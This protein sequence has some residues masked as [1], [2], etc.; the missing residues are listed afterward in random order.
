MS[1]ARII[2]PDFFQSRSLARVSRDARLTFIGLWTEADAEGRGIAHPAILRG[3]IWP[4]DVDITDAVVVSH[5]YELASTG[6]ITVYESDGDA[7]FAVVSWHKH[8]SAAYRTGESKLPAP[9]SCRNSPETLYRLR[10]SNGELLYVGITR[11]WPLRMR[12][13]CADKAWW[14]EV[15]NV[16]LVHMSCTRA[17]IEAIEKAVIHEE[18]PKYNVAHNAPVRKLT[19]PKPKPTVKDERDELWWEEADDGS[20]ITY[21]K[22]D[23]VFTF[24]MV[25]TLLDCLHRADGTMDYFVDFDACDIPLTVDG[26]CPIRHAVAGDKDL[27][28]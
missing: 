16:E 12:Q 13:H 27:D 22:N 9:E 20:T 24:G 15:A 7:F 21:Y 23:R 5:L 6:H 1:R 26:S 8:Q 4:L 28:W 25:G 19:L 3:R 2:K 17:Q 11:D 10:A 14:R 18:R